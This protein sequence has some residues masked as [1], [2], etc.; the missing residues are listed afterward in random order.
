M[1]PGARVPAPW[2]VAVAPGGALRAALTVAGADLR[3]DL[4]LHHRLGEY[5]DRLTQEV[6][7]APGCLLAEQLQ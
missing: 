4:G 6:E 5:R 3:G 7:V 1:V 2:P